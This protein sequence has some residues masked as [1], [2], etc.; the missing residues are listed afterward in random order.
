MNDPASA[1]RP[2]ESGQVLSISSGAHLVVS[3]PAVLGAI[4]HASGPL[5]ARKLP[6]PPTAV[7]TRNAVAVAVVISELVREVEVAPRTPGGV[8]EI[9][10]APAEFARRAG[11][12][13]SEAEAAVSLLYAAGV[14]A[15]VESPSA[16]RLR[17]VDG[18]LAEEPTLAL[19]AWEEVRTRL[20]A[21]RATL[22]PA[23]AVVRELARASTVVD[24]ANG[25][26]WAN[27]TLGRLA[28]RTFFQRTALSTAIT[29]LESAG[30]IERGQRRGQEGQYRLLPSA[31]GAEW[32]RPAAGPGLPRGL[33]PAAPALPGAAAAAPLDPAPAPRAAAPAVPMQIAGVPIEV[34]PGV[35]VRVEI[36]ALGRQFVHVG[37]HV[38]IGPL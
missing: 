7:D 33:A 18:M 34:P 32:P 25:S 9:P 23:M 35:S 26:G 37:P 22:P 12:S 31:F 17:F 27:A 10:E 15:R 28:D 21:V 11:T 20:H 24:P 14:L 8:V 30:L 29:A 1:H 13:L 5:A 6:R 4:H 38:V 19:V 2:A 36:D 16:A 3:V